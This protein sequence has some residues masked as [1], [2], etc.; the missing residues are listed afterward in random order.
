[1]RYAHN[2]MMVGLKPM[3]L[4]SPPI[5]TTLSVWVISIFWWI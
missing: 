3:R 4:L 1:V 2:A 5:S